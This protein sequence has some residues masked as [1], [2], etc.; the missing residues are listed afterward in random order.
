MPLPK[1]IEDIVNRLGSLDGDSAHP[2][3]WLAEDINTF[4]KEG[5][6]AGKWT[7]G[8]KHAWNR[9]IYERIRYNFE[10]L[11]DSDK[12]KQ[13]SRRIRDAARNFPG[14]TVSIRLFVGQIRVGHSFQSASIEQTRLVGAPE[15]IANR[16][17][18]EELRG[19]NLV[20]GRLPVERLRS[21]DISADQWL[22]RIF[23]YSRK[24]AWVVANNRGFTAHC[25]ADL[26]PLRLIP[27]RYAENSHEWQ[28]LNEVD[29]DRTLPST[30]SVITSG[31]AN[32]R[33]LAT[34]R[35]PVQW[36]YF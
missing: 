14:A 1:Y 2:F 25:L 4:Y 12:N 8:E 13:E 26:R 28:R 32:N 11:T 19:D 34:A 16:P 15:D 20:P 24:N 23:H 22:I 17:M 30:E 33:I 6:R 18:S 27:T 9:I 36:S 21:G 5:L 29:G 35:V 10:K 7:S 3:H 31:R